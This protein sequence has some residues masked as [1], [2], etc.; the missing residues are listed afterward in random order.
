MSRVGGNFFLHLPPVFSFL[1]RTSRSQEDTTVDHAAIRGLAPTFLASV[2]GLPHARDERT[3]RPLH[4]A[5]GDTKPGRRL[6]RERW[7]TSQACTSTPRH[8]S[9]CGG[10]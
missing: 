4:A 9:A 5:E 6:C 10:T 7:E 8:L 3:L 2:G 1:Y